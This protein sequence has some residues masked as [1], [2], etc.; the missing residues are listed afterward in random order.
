MNLYFRLG[1][2]RNT[3]CIIFQSATIF[4]ALGFSLFL[5]C[6][7]MIIQGY[8]TV[9]IKRAVFCAWGVVLQRP[10]LRHHF[11]DLSVLVIILTSGFLW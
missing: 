8:F 5:I 7:A 10:D 4:K 1:S 3:A 6:T 11:L 2:C 9:G